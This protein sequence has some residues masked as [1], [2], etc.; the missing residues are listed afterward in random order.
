MY[1][2][3]VNWFNTYKEEDSISHLLIPAADW[4]DAMQKVSGEFE[5]IN[6]IEMKEINFEKYDVVYLPEDVVEAVIEENTY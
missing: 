5:F 3:K 2:A 6:S 1:Y 4:N